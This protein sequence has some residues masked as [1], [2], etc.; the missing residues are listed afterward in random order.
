MVFLVTDRPRVLAAVVAVGAATDLLDG[1]IARASHTE[2]EVGALLDP[3][4][5]KVFVL[6]GLLSFLPGGG[7]DWA[8][9][10][11]L[12]LRD[13]FTGGTYLLGRLTGR[14]IPFRSRLGGK[15]TTALQVGTLFSLLFWPRWVSLFV[16]LVGIAAV[17]AI[18]D[19]GMAGI[20]NVQRQQMV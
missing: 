17:Y 4:C 9:L 5:D 1:L 6:M 16:L 8:A 15:V 20:R 19:Y 7:L 18:V 3:F 11:I 12:I 13:I 2:S 14:I 10:L